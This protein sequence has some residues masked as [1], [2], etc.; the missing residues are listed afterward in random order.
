MKQS[1]VKSPLSYK[2]WFCQES[3]NDK[4]YNILVLARF[5]KN[6]QIF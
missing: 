2:N 4:M 5:V 6:L 1:V 3:K